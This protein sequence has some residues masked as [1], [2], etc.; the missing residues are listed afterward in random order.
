MYFFLL[1]QFHSFVRLLFSPYGPH[2]PNVGKKYT[3]V[4]CTAAMHFQH[5]SYAYHNASK[6][7]HA[8]NG[9]VALQSDGC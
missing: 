5:S 6:T 8:T 1:F 4:F 9:R 3:E 2:F 7:R